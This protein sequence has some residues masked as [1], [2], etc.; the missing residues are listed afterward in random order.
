MSELDPKSGQRARVAAYRQSRRQNGLRETTIW[1]HEGD[2][3]RIDELI[4]TGKF[5]NRSE[6]VHQ[7]LE[8]FFTTGS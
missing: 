7:A 2:Q 3:S 4:A 6:I 8:A 1:F 5:K